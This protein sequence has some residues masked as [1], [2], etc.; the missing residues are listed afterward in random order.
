MPSSATGGNTLCLS[1]NE[2]L[3]IRPLTI[4]ALFKKIFMALDDG[5]PVI[6]SGSGKS[7][8]VVES[9]N[10]SKTIVRIVVVLALTGL[11]PRTADS[12]RQQ[13]HEAS[14]VMWRV[15][16]VALASPPRPHPNGSLQPPL[17]RKPGRHI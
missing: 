11:L 1:N 3:Y 17:L 6:G 15:H 7:S 2:P 5:W 4:A 10:F 13:G 14:K 16:F 9:T 8:Q 12:S